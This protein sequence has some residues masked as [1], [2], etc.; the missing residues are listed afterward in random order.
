MQ[1]AVSHQG[2]GLNMLEGSLP[3]W[4]PARSLVRPTPVTSTGPCEGGNISGGAEPAWPW[5][6][7]RQGWRSAM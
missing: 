1:S 2:G 6:H 3:A 5:P 7:K 4:L